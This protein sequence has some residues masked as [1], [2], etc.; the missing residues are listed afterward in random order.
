MDCNVTALMVRAVEADNPSVAARIVVEPFANPVA[1]PPGDVIVATAS[2]D[3]VHAAADE[4][5]RVLPSL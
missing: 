5:S 1:R 4:S 2:L 3:E